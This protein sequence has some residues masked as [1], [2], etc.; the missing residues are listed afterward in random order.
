MSP[1]EI[2]YFLNWNILLKV[3]TD[4]ENILKILIFKKP[5]FLDFVTTAIPIKSNWVKYI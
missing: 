3:G 1:Y 2:L 5:L 4:F